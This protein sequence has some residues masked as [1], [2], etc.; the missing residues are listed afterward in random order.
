MA[1]PVTPEATGAPSCDPRQPCRDAANRVG[2]ECPAGRN[3]TDSIRICH[4]VRSIPDHRGSMGRPFRTQIPLHGTPCRFAMTS[5]LRGVA[6][7]PAQQ[8]RRRKGV[9][10]GPYRPRRTWRPW[11][12]STGAERADRRLRLINLSRGKLRSDQ[13][14]KPWNPPRPQIHR[15]SASSQ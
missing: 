10:Q 3:P 1:A 9:A 5:G 13:S 4:N 8:Q 6:T 2:P 15:P 11:F 12:V 7:M 14:R